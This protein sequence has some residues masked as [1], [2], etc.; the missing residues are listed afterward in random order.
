VFNVLGLEERLLG[1]GSNSPP[2]DLI[3]FANY[4]KFKFL[5]AV[6]HQPSPLSMRIPSAVNWST[7]FCRYIF[8]VSRPGLSGNLPSLRNSLFNGD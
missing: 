3:A 5:D 1:L 7:R 2:R 8:K 4:F 6:L